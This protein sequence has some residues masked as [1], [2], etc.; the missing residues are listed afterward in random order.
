MAQIILNCMHIEVG[1]KSVC[2]S[3]L[4]MNLRVCKGK[5]WWDTRYNVVATSISRD[6]HLQHNL[7][8]LMVS[9]QRLPVQYCWT[10]FS[11]LTVKSPQGFCIEKSRSPPQNINGVHLLIVITLAFLSIRIIVLPN[12]PFPDTKNV[13]HL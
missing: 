3:G 2:I 9:S 1:N 8:P 13:W 5:N 11:R 7:F 6:Q 10:K 12:K 4:C